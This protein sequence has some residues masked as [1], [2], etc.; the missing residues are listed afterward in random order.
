VRKWLR[1]VKNLSG[2][3]EKVI[4]IHEPKIARNLHDE[5]EMR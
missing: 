3:E 5:D 2:T 4:H 1:H